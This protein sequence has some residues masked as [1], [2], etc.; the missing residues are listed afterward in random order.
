MV[1]GLFKKNKDKQK[2]RA[3]YTSL[4]VK[5][6]V[7]ETPDAVTIIF[8]QPDPEITYE[9]GQYLTCICPLDNQ[10]ERRAYS[11]NSS[12]FLKELPAI[13]VK[14]ESE[15]KVSNYLYS[16]VKPGDTI[17]ALEPMGN[18]TTS[19]DPDNKR[20]LVFIGGGSGITPL[21]S[22]M[23]TVLQMEK[24]SKVTLIYSNRN[25]TSIIF[26]EK[27]HKLE[28]EHKDRLKIYHILSQPETDSYG[29]AGRLTDVRL[30]EILN[31]VTDK[32]LPGEY[33]LCG[34]Q[35]LMQMAE[36]ELKNQGV[37]TDNIKKESF[38]ASS[39]LAGEQASYDQISEVT[40]LMDGEEYNFKVEPGKTILE[41][42]LDNDIDMPFSCQS[43]I[44][45]TC[46][47]KKLEGEVEMDETDGLTP[48][49]LEEGYVLVCVGHP[50]TSKLKL[51]V[52]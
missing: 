43:G 44:C 26:K 40:V 11:L 47:C 32:S 46:R 6:V 13:T 50:K 38:V 19:F 36:A 51:E 25:E 28:Q 29:P 14:R 45:T 37:A 8:E 18:F 4:K 49:E 5:E 21:M 30:R 52:D 3:N 16:Q 22:I 17:K 2:K 41:T 33:Y 23:S 24:Q 20:H 31:E 9:S 7:K 34:P 10:E 15:G 48:E 35:G 27:L 42:A 39:D 12:A 1:F